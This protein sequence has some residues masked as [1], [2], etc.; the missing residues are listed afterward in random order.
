VGARLD[1][2]A[3]QDMEARH[4]ARAKKPNGHLRFMNTNW[5][6]GALGHQAET[7]RPTRSGEDSSSIDGLADCPSEQTSPL[8]VSNLATY[9][10]FVDNLT[11][12]IDR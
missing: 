6:N 10:F 5:R 4:D 8:P 9:Q 7:A 1:V 11:M 12:A 3:I 2:L